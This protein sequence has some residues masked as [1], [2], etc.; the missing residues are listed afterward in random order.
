MWHLSPQW[1]RAT[2]YCAISRE[3]R[4]Q[5]G[6]ILRSIRIAKCELD[7]LQDASD[8]MSEFRQTLLHG[9][10]Q[11]SASSM[12]CCTLNKMLSIR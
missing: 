11:Y 5:M 1:K 4:I 2:A 9:F 6:S 12:R 3:L 8:C 10:Y 7:N